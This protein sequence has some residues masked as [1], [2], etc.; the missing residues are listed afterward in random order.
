VNIYHL[1]FIKQINKIK[2][3]NQN[4]IKNLIIE[5][6]KIKKQILEIENSIVYEQGNLN[7]NNLCVKNE[8]KNNEIIKPFCSS[9][10]LK[11]L[12]QFIFKLESEL[13]TA[14]TKNKDFL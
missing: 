2:K 5:K 3:I 9:E 8:I 7:N 1:T 10:E 4:F 12:N 11:K 6:E 14:N 13:A